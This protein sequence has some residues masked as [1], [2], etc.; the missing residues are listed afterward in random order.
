MRSRAPG[1]LRHLTVDEH[2]FGK[3]ARFFHLQP[4]VITLAGAL[5]RPTEDGESA[6][7]HG[8]VVDELHDEDGFAHT[9]SAEEANLPPHARTA[10]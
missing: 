9:G 6:V 5:A 7:M 3:D 4:E 1:G 8:H 2:G 10:G